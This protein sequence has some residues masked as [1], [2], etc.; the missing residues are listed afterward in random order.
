MSKLNQLQ[1][2]LIENN[3]DAAFITTPDNVCVRLSLNIEIAT[4]R[5]Y[6]FVFPYSFSPTR[7]SLRFRYKIL[8]FSKPFLNF[9]IL[10]FIYQWI[11]N[12]I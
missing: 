8:F 1:H 10:V 3:I 11:F 9:N 7:N 5:P 12:N 2:H 6:S 4:P